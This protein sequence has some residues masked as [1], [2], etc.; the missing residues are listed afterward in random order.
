MTVFISENCLQLRPKSVFM[1][2]LTIHAHQKEWASIG[3]QCKMNKNKFYSRSAFIFFSSYSS[4]PYK[5]EVIG[6][7]L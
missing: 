3:R 6:D 5:E 2:I 4:Q 1:P 7:E